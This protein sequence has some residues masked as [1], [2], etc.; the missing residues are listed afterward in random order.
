MKDST[1]SVIVLPVP[2]SVILSVAEAADTESKELSSIVICPLPLIFISA[3]FAKP[4]LLCRV[5]PK[6]FCTLPLAAYVNAC[7]PFLTVKSLVYAV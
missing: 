2:K 7:S 6:V 3:S 5:I 1:L 4:V